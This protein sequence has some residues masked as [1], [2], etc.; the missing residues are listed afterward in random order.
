MSDARTRESR[1][2]LNAL[3]VTLGVT[4][5]LSPQEIETVN[6]ELAKAGAVCRNELA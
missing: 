6:R 5:H 3:Y 4:R 1:D 2:T